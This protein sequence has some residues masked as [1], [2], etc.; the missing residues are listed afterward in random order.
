MN[1]LK[2]TVT[3]LVP[4]MV[5]YVQSKGMAFKI[6]SHLLGESVSRTAIDVYH[7]SLTP[8]NKMRV[9]RE[10]RS[11]SSHILGA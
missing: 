9:Y 4:K 1:L 8:A 2:T 11:G 7:A 3:A 5:V 10:F 6:Y